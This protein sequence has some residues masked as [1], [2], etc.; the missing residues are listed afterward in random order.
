MPEMFSNV[1]SPAAARSPLARTIAGTMTAKAKSVCRVIGT[2]SRLA[3]SEGGRKRPITHLRTSRILREKVKAIRHKASEFGAY[4]TLFRADVE[5]RGDRLDKPT[6]IHL[7]LVSGKGSAEKTGR[8]SG[9][10]AR[11]GSGR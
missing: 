3:R 4:A 6:G 7:Y 1:I 8:P 9:V 11:A 2:S 10:I 5:D